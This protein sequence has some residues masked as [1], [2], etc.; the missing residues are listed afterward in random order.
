[1]GKAAVRVGVAVLM[2][3]GASFAISVTVSTPA[4][5]TTVGSPATINARASSAYPITGWRIYVDNNNVY[6]AGATANISA[7]LT[8]ATGTHQVI[9][10]A[11]DSSGAYASQ[12][13]Q[14]TV[15][16]TAVTVS[17]STPINGATVGSP[18]TVNASA[19][20]TYP[21]T[22]WH[23]YV[24]GV[25]AYNGGAS[26]TIS[27]SLAVSAGS[28]QV[29]VRAWNS[30]GA[31]GSVYLTLTATASSGPMPPAT[32]TTLANLE[33]RTWS[34][35]SSAS[36]SGGV[37]AASSYWAAPY[38]TSPSLDGS[39]TVFATAGPAYATALYWEHNAQT[40]VPSHFIFDFNLY[41][42]QASTTA[43]EALEFDFFQVAN[44]LKY[45]FG[46]QCNY[47]THTWDVW[48]EATQHWIH[49]NATCAKFQP[50]TWHHVKWAVER[51]GS[52]THYLSVT[53]DGV[54]QAISSSYAYQPAVAT[55]WAEGS[56]GIQVQ[57]DLSSNPGNGFK[58]WIDRLTLYQW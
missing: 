45:M 13:L 32:A 51:Y 34:S 43:A 1:M 24:D 28:H 17:V 50:N 12:T 35:C 6:G 31:Y 48:N 2:L 36:C 19:S 52:Q 5:Y 3:V 21:V 9:V 22:G 23:I 27:A 4:N 8:M 58:E 26:S 15:A 33:D 40:N 38:Q 16:G 54:T 37:A 53:V 30:T 39:S 18:A 20:S 42:D 55:N 7:S 46:T 57:Q 49:S 10:R 14:L 29:I 56:N 25:N 41:P 11:W 44:G 47:W